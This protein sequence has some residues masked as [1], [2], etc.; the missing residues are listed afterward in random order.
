[1]EDPRLL[2]LYYGATVV[3]VVLDVALVGLILSMTVRIM[4]PSDAI[5]EENARSVTV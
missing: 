1:M 3:F 4:V 2:T 5:F